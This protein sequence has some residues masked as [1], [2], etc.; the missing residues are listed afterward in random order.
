MSNFQFWNSQLKQFFKEIAYVFDKSEVSLR[1]LPGKMQAS[2]IQG[3]CNHAGF[4]Y[5]HCLT[6]LFL[7]QKVTAHFSTGL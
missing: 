2:V 3:L 7:E 5:N 6:T 1:I 4:S